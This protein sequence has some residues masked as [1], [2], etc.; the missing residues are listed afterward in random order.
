[1]AVAPRT[2]ALGASPRALRGGGGRHI[3]GLLGRRDARRRRG[4]ELGGWIE[5]RR[6]IELRERVELGRWIE[7]RERFELGSHGT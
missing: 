1:M 4:G 6:W 7:L 3:A 2:G 5:L